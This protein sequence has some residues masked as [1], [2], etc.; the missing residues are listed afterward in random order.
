MT[1]KRK[2][3]DDEELALDVERGD[4]TRE[5]IAAKH[6]ISRRHL[7][8]L[9]HGRARPEFARRLARARAELRGDIRRRLRGLQEKAVNTLAGAMDE[10]K[11]V[12]PTALA[13]AKEVLNRCLPEETHE[14]D[15]PTLVDLLPGLAELTPETL[16]QVDKELGT[17]LA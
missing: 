2:P 17:P 14:Q 13:A 10:D 5:A 3:Y 8:D 1:A 9:I 12:S 6:G 7:S 4:M 11:K 15:L 16:A